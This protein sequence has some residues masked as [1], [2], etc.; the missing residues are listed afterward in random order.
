M[1]TFYPPVYT[2]TAA[3]DLSNSINRFIGFD[4]KIC[5]PEAKALGILLANTN[6]GD[7]AP[8]AITG[9]AFVLTDFDINRGQLVEC[10]ADGKANCI[11]DGIANGIAMGTTSG[12]IPN[13]M[14]RI[15]LYGRIPVLGDVNI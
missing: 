3:E 4:G 7:Q 9:V 10:S 5:A 8:I 6:M 1:R 12:N 14:L 15:S 2:I 13:Q 11:E